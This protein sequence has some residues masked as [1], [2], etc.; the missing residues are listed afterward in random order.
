MLSITFVFVTKN[1]NARSRPYNQRMNRTK[2][3]GPVDMTVRMIEV[4]ERA[5]VSVMTVS[6]TLRAPDKVAASSRAKVLSAIR[7]LGYVPDAQ[8]ASLSSKRSGFVSLLVPSLNNPHFGE[9]VMG[10]KRILEPQGIQVLLGFTN[11]QSSEE[12][13]LI[14]WMLERRPEAIVLTYDGHTQR[15]RELLEQAGV[16]VIEAWEIPPKPIQ[17]VVGFSNHD[18]AATMTK[19]LIAKGYTRIAYIGESDDQGTRGGQRRKGFVAAMKQAGLSAERQIAYAPPPI[20]MEQGKQALE[21]LLNRWP[22]TDAVLCVS[23]PCAFGALSHCLARGW[24]VPQ[25]V[26]IAGFGAFE[27]S[28]HSVPGISTLAVSGAEIGERSAEVILSLIRPHLDV[29]VKPGQRIFRVKTEPLLR[30]ST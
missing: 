27:V 15:S 14:S 29:S 4:A 28:A 19:S 18:A 30:Q 3:A 2:P 24:K 20:N 25:R 8:A 16:P 23:D 5:G 12:E 13:R 17:Y 26:A 22:D 1:L 7:E 21:A 11:Y 9:T 10:M 6:R